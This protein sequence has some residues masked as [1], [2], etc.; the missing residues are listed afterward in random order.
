VWLPLLVLLAVSA[1]CDS[2]TTSEVTTGPTPAKCHLT[3]A[4]PS[5]IVATGGTAAVSIT[6]QPECPWEV[7]TQAN[8]ISNVSPASGQGNG[9]VEFVAAENPVP[10]MREGELVINDNRVRVMQEAAPCLFS[11][12]PEQRTLTA[13]ANTNSFTVET[14]E[15]CK[16]T[17]RS[18]AEWITLTA[19]VDGAGNGTVAYRVTSNGG[20]TRTGTVTVGNGTHTVIQQNAASGPSPSPAPPAPP[21]PPPCTYAISPTS[22]NVGAAGGPGGTVTVTTAAHCLWT[23]TSN[24]S[25]LI[26]TSGA[27]GTGNGSVGFAADFN[28]TGSPRSGTL[29]IAGRTFTVSQIDAAPEPCT[30]AVNPSSASLSALGGTGSIVVSARSGCAWTASNNAWWITF[31]SGSSGNGNGRVDYLVLP[32]VGTARSSSIAIAEHSFSVSQDGVLSSQ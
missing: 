12:D 31:T 28:G 5:N 11:I 8:W 22:R 14:H 3:L 16:W 18:T 20:S 32:N 19:G 15:A 29:T 4:P 6:A 23:A 1:G 21:P 10:S 26:I 17:A 24:A 2:S 30:Y 27:T 9:T 25:W 7:S 13:D